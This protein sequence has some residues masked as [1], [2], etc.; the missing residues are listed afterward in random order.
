VALRLAYQIERVLEVN[1]VVALLE[2]TGARVA[3]VAGTDQR[4]VGTVLGPDT[5]FARVAEGNARSMQVRGGAL[6]ELVPDRRKQD[7]TEITMLHLQDHG[8]PIGGVAFWRTPSG[9]LPSSALAEVREI[10]HQA[11]PRLRAAIATEKIHDSTRNDPLTGLPNRKTLEEHVQR[12]GESDGAL[13]VADLDR[14]KEL[15]DTLGNPA[16]DAALVHFARVL[17]GEVRGDD[18][19]ARIGGEEFAVWLP[20]TDMAAALRVAERIRASLATTAWD[21]QGRPWSLSASFG[22]AGCPETTRNVHNLM[23]RADSALSQ[24]KR[25]GRDRVAA[26][27]AGR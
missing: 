1:V 12:L 23:S 26:A 4:L 27:P 16:G 24:A 9:P 2:P 25:S 20:G 6:G 11:E 13:I 18:I 22:V 7:H 17:N 3:A 21:W 5:P 15:N 19:A 8:E 14:F 10:L